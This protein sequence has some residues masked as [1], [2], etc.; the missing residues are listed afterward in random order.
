MTVYDSFLQEAN[1]GVTSHKLQPNQTPTPHKRCYKNTTIINWTR[2][3]FDKAMFAICPKP[4]ER[5]G[6]LLGPIGSNDIS[7]FFFDAGANVTG[8]SYSPDYVTLNRKLKEEWIPAGIDY[9]G[10]IHS[11][12]GRLDRL[13]SADLIYIGRLL[14]ANPDMPMF[15]APIVIPPE[16]RM[17]MMVVFRDNPASVVE[18]HINFF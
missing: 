12:P 7:D 15:V 13:S 14:T 16:F 11:H 1:P 3:A 2:E 8:A 9:K 17:R 18:A 6:L 4:P 5:G 10:A